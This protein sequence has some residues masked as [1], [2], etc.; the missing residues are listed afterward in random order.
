M[1]GFFRRKKKDVTNKDVIEKVIKKEV[2]PNNRMLTIIRCIYVSD[3]LYRVHWRYESESK[4]NRGYTIC[5]VEGKLTLSTFELLVVFHEDKI[6]KDDNN[7]RG[8]RATVCSESSGCYSSHSRKYNK[9]DLRKRL[10]HCY[11]CK[12]RLSSELDKKCSK[13]GWLKCPVCGVCE[14]SCKEVTVVSSFVSNRPTIFLKSE[15]T[16]DLEHENRDQ[17]DIVECSYDKY[18]DAYEEKIYE[19]D[20]DLS[21][22]YGYADEVDWEDRF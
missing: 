8:Q 4:R 12:T 3:S 1:F 9:Y 18:N 15:D 17:G 2:E 13:C 7:Y 11:S 10:T 19:E 6:I 14:Y 20:Y 16:T 22:D 5:R 21:V